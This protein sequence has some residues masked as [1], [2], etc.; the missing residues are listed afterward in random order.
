MNYCGGIISRCVRVNRESAGTARATRPTLW[1]RLRLLGSGLS[2][3]IDPR[4]RLGSSDHTCHQG[5][6]S[7]SKEDLVRRLHPQP[8]PAPLHHP[9]TAGTR[10]NAVCQ[11]Q[12]SRQLTLRMLA[13]ESLEPRV[14]VS[15]PVEMQTPSRDQMEQQRGHPPPKEQRNPHP[16]GCCEIN[17]TE[18]PALAR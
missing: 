15:G 17:C 12:N 10:L 5:R 16:Q 2:Q 13:D 18:H 14:I 11:V 9:P 7:N 3:T 1:N 8:R 4:I 6:C